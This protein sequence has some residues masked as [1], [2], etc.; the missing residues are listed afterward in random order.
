MT[1]KPQLLRAYSQDARMIAVLA[2]RSL[3]DQL[4]LASEL[5][6]RR[7]VKKAE[8]AIAKAIRAATDPEDRAACFIRRAQARLMSA[9]PDDALDDI[10]AAGALDRE[11]GDNP[12][13]LELEADA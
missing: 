2:E 5:L 8:I 9:R 7:E 1:P 13:Y 10:R 12:L 4:Q 6:E 11:H 3:Q